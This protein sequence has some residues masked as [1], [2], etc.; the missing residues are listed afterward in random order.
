[1]SR[2]CG[3]MMYFP[4]HHDAT[5]GPMRTT[6]TLD[7]DV[8]RAVEELRRERGLGVSAALN[9]LARQGLSSG[10]EAG[11]RFTQRV[12]PLGPPR[13]PLDDIGA[14]LDLIEGE[15]RRG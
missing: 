6:V 7:E 2:W 10:A 8:A 3:I 9:A 4:Q 1:M 13:I 5:V 11:E 15:T 12:S 14:A